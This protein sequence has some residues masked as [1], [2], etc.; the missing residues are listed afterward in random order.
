MVVVTWD[1]D[2]TYETSDSQSTCSTSN[3]K[4]S[5]VEFRDVNT[6]NTEIAIMSIDDQLKMIKEEKHQEYLPST[7]CKLLSLDTKEWLTGSSYNH[8]KDNSFSPYQHK[9][10]FGQTLYRL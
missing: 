1:F 10:C 9:C 3:S 2:D 5:I 6:V 8:H 4:D 7:G